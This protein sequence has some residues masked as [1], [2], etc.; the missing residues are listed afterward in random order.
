MS[1]LKKMQ[2]SSIKA[3]TNHNQNRRNN[4][5]DDRVQYQVSH[6]EVPIEIIPS[7]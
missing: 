1:L 3:S 5:T 7:K 4:C 2:K 6:K